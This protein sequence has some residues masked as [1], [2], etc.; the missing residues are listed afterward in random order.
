MGHLKHKNNMVW[1]D[2]EMTGLDP[3]KEGIIEV[4]TIITNCNLEILA[5]GPNLVVHQTRKLLKGMDSWNQKQ[6]AKSGLAEAVLKSKVTVKQAEKATL[7]FIKQYCYPGKS[8]LCGNAVYHDR[9]FIIKYMPK[10]DKFLHYRLV[11][12]TTVK[13]LSSYWYPKDKAVAP[14]K[15]ESH[16][17]LDDIRESIEELRFYRE[18]FFKESRSKVSATD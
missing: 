16:R 15:A 13:L 11:D 1:I 3:E 9:R 17:A 2:M 10:I 18:N 4:A 7:D 5:E 14:K 12:V 8:S 6:H